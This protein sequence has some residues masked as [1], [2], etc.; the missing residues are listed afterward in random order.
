[1]YGRLRCLTVWPSSR[2]TTIGVSIGTS[3]MNRPWETPGIVTV[4]KGVVD[5]RCTSTPLH[6]VPPEAYVDDLLLGVV[7]DGCDP[8]R[9]CDVSPV[10]HCSVP[11]AGPPLHR[12]IASTRSFSQS[13]FGRLAGVTALDGTHGER[14][15]ASSSGRARTSQTREVGEAL[16]R[17][18]RRIERHA[19]PERSAPDLDDESEADGEGDPERNLAASAVFGQAPPAGAAAGELP[20]RKPLKE[21]GGL[22]RN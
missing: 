9:I 6:A 18:L 19:S 14:R 15:T 12:A 10:D 13:D 5:T 1:M 17:L 16:E 22:G 2:M 21:T 4:P 3:R 8:F 11:S 7:C 20:A